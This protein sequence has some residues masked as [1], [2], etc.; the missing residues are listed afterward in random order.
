[1]RGIRTG[2]NISLTSEDCNRLV[3]IVGDR[4]VAQKRVWCTSIIFFSAA[5]LGTHASM[6]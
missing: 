2:I 4:N 3:V 5:G 6:R 1:M